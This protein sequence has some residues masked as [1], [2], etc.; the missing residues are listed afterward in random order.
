MTR[1]VRPER[2]RSI[3]AGS[4]GPAGLPRIWL[5]RVTVVSAPRTTRQAAEKLVEAVSKGRF[6]SGHDFSRA[7][8]A[9]KQERAL[10]PE[11][12]ISPLL[13]ENRSFSAASRDA[14][15]RSVLSHPF[16]KERE[17]DGAPMISL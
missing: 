13:P 14:G 6:V 8:N 16:R 4:A 12:C 2:R 17:K 3:Q 9:T 15:S 11:G 10:A 5:S 7:V 1:W